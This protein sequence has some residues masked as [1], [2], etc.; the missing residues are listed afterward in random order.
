[1]KHI[2]ISAL[3]I[4]MIITMPVIALAQA[5]TTRAKKGCRLC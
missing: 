1:M 4:I 5:D 3:A 2:F